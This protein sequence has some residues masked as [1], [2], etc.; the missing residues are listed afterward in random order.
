MDVGG[1]REREREEG[2]REKG[3]ETRKQHLDHQQWKRSIPLGA[4]DEK[5]SGFQH[6][7]AEARQIPNQTGLPRTT[8]LPVSSQNT[9]STEL[10]LCAY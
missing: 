3:R 5:D 10:S 2:G 4:L 9:Y 8:R 7:R 1:C 6:A